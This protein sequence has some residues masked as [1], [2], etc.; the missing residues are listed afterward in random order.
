MRRTAILLIVGLSLTAAPALAAGTSFKTGHYTGPSSQ[1]FKFTLRVFYTKLC[2]GLEVRRL[3]V[4][5]VGR[6]KIAAK[7]SG[8]S[9]EVI[10][11]PDTFQA[12]VGR[13][14]KVSGSAGIENIKWSLTI[15]PKGTIKGSLYFKGLQLTNENNTCRS[16]KVSFALKRG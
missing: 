12:I 14:G 15:S 1:H 5:Q 3:C 10:S 6:I 9:S 16:G 8:G 2:G 7:C 11:S 13:S 4:E